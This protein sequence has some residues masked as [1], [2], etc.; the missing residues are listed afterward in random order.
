MADDT[1][2]EQAA[3]NAIDAEVAAEGFYTLLADGAQDPQIRE[4]FS[5][6]ADQERDHAVHIHELAKQL[7]AGKL[8]DKPDTEVCSIET[9]MGWRTTR[10]AGSGVRT[11]T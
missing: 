6:M 1:T 5:L 9:C 10:R 8:A 7:G 11:V 4:F 2:L 3:R